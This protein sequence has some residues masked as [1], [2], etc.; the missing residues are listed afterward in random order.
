[1][2][3]AIVSLHRT[4]MLLPVM[5]LTTL[6]LSAYAMAALAQA[7][8]ETALAPNGLGECSPM[9]SDFGCGHG[10]GCACHLLPET[11]HPV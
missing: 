2:K 6:S 5:S 4:N 3:R 9:T 11:E 7:L 1:M 10:F 8:P